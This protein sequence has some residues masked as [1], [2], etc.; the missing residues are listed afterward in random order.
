M[1]DRY[2]RFL[3][4]SM[5]LLC[6]LFGV[7][8]V[9]LRPGYLSSAY[10][11][12]VLIILQVVVAALW[13][14]RQ[15]FFPLV[16]GAFLWAAI[17]VPLH[18][19]WT[20]GRWF[21]LAIGALAGYV[22]YMKD[23]HHRFGTFHLVALFC[24]LAAVVSA[25]VSSYPTVATLKALSL[26][27]LF[28][29]GASGARLAVIGRE[30]NFLSGLLL[31]CEILVYV[32]A[33][34]YFVFGFE[35]FDHP[36]SRGAVMGV[37]AVPM[38]LWGILIGGSVGTCRRRTF[39]FVLA[40]LLLLSSYARAGIA[41]GAVACILLCV[42]LRRYRLLLKGVG[43]ALLSAVLVAAVVP[44]RQ[45]ESGSLSAVFLYKGQQEMGVL[46]SRRSAWDRTSSVI[47][48]HPWFGSGFGTSIT[49]DQWTQKVGSFE[50]TP[51][52]TR[53]HGNSYLAITEWVGLLG[54][55]PFF[56]L[57]FLVTVNVGRVVVWMRRAGDPFSPAVPVAAVLAAGLVHAGFE[58]WLFAVGYYVCVFFWTFAFVLVDVLPQT[59]PA[60]VQAD[61]PRSSPQWR[62]SFG[63]AAPG[64]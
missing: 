29:Y 35:L 32:L 42:S 10:Y 28:L 56:A 63:M 26:L 21:I 16:I 4:S 49:H 57:V 6:C 27:L 45:I 62:S 11:L 2:S 3:A 40:L 58:D 12:G 7:C 38:L 53:E 41:G 23:R 5:M 30:A 52:A 20:S 60:F 33:I 51:Q 14:Y 64:R 25:M 1:N 36:N 37:V 47:R 8:I 18:E 55:M 48:E 13:N 39:A 43:V 54:V 61:T 15:R 34:T 17:A 22:I 19:A 24:V 46:A 59:A 50:S 31:G 9:V 44:L